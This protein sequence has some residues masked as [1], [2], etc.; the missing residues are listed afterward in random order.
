MD[1]WV[2]LAVSAVVLGGIALAAS[3]LIE[4]RRR[5]QRRRRRWTQAGLLDPGDNFDRDMMDVDGVVLDDDD[6]DFDL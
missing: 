4:R 1:I 2:S 5:T 3:M 6:Y